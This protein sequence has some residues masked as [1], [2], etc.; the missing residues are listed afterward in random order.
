MEGHLNGKAVVEQPWRGDLSQFFAR[1]EVAR[2]C[3][4][5]VELPRNLRSSKLLEPT[6]GQGAFI[7]LLIPRL[8]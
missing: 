8:A 4:C 6:A 2:V 5:Q 3:L 1:Q 7:L